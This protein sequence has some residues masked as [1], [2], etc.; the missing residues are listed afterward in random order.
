MISLYGAPIAIL[1]DAASMIPDPATKELKGGM[2][3][4]YSILGM[5]FV[6]DPQIIRKREKQRAAPAKT[7]KKYLDFN[8]IILLSL[9]VSIN[10]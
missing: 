1:R 5:G 3:G 6:L 8:L 4:G 7:T 9:K 2:G 10:F